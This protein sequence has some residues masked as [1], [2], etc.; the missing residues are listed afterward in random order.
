MKAKP[1]G[2]LT[3]YE[4]VLRTF[5]YWQQVVPEEHAEVRAALEQ[6]LEREADN[7]EACACLSRIYLDEF[8]FDF[9]VQPDS[10]DRGLHAA[11]R[12]VELDATSQLA[13]RSLAEAHYLRKERGAFFQAADRVLELN[14][15]DT[16]NVGMIG[17]LIAIAGEWERGCKAVR[18][19]MQLNPHHAGWLHFVFFER[20]YHNREY[21][22]A[23][24]AAEKVNMP[25]HYPLHADLAIVNAQLG[26][27]EEARKH[28]KTLVELAPDT[29]RNYPAEMSKW[30]FSDELV[31]HKLEGLRKA[32]L[33]VDA[34]KG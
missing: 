32:G 7:A 22:Q 2:A 34:A 20:H 1:A 26:R 27:M 31:E 16:N 4:C 8:R 19:V 29:A 13:Y 6:A 15:R 3:A 28:L 24:E 23:L 5:L 9:N 11:R 25:G 12:A 18:K 14:P 10:L 21:E 30:Y 33:D 17:S